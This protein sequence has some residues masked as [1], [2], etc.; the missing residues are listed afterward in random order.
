MSGQGKNVEVSLSTSSLVLEPSYISL[1]SSKTFKIR[2]SSD[3][4]ISYVWKSFSSE[5]EEIAERERLL[6]EIN[7]MEEIEQSALYTQVQELY[8]PD[9][10]KHMSTAEIE[11]FEAYLEG[12]QHNN[13]VMDN[14][15]GTF[16]VPF[17]PASAKA[18]MAQLVRKYRSVLLILSRLF[19]SLSP[20]LF[21]FPSLLLF[22]FRFYRYLYFS[23]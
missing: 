4:P 13:Q 23:G 3:S 16:M 9:N 8:A 18:D 2:N 5:E 10:I 12:A 17:L 15:S 1:L 7:H 11:E 20:L 14:D 22:L 19:P 6:L 21:L